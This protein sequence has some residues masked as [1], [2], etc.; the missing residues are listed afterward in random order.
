MHI[1]IKYSQAV[2]GVAVTVLIAVMLC[3]CGK[4]PNVRESYPSVSQVK[5]REGKPID[6]VTVLPQREKVIMKK[7]ADD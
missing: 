3:G 1:S 7:S 5:P 4:G 2:V 6:Q